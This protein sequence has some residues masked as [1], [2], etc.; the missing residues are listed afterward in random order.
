[1]KQTMR[2][3]SIGETAAA[4]RYR[5]ETALCREM[6]ESF[7]QCRYCLRRGH[8]VAGKF[9]ISDY[10]CSFCGAYLYP[11]CKPEGVCDGSENCRFFER[12]QR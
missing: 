3:E 2:E 5:A 6:H 9:Y 11:A 8:M 1:M 12:D 4:A 7:A 10:R